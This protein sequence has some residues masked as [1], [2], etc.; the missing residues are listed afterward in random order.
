M[1][2][3]F[4]ISKGILLIYTVTEIGFRKSDMPRVIISGHPF[5]I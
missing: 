3:T 5:E 2:S 4:E 1:S